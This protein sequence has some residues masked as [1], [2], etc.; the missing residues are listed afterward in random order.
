MANALVGKTTVKFFFICPDEKAVSALR[1]F[2]E[3]HMEFMQNKSHREGPLKLIQYEISEGPEW[4]NLE[5]FYDGK[6]PSRTGRTIFTLSEIYETEDGL[7]HHWMESKEFGPV[8]PTLMEENNIDLQVFNQ[9][10]IIQ[11]LWD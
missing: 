11:S 6:F 8:L 10:K 9:M 4:A 3:G 7:H 1:I 2:F 5:E